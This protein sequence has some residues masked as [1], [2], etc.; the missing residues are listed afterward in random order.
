MRGSMRREIFKV[1][2][3]PEKSP[4]RL[5]SGNL[6]EK[7]HPVRGDYTKLLN[8]NPDRN[9]HFNSDRNLYFDLNRELT[10]DL[11]RSLSF[12]PDRDLGIGKRGIV[13]R[14]YVCSSCGALVNPM[15]TECD[16]CDAVFEKAPKRKAK[17]PKKSA[18]VKRRFCH[19]CGY[20]TTGS[21]AYCSHC[22]MRLPDSPGRVDRTEGEEASG[23]QPYDALKL[24]KKEARKKT[25]T[26]W[27]D[28]GKRLE[29][30]LE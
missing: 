29:D 23:E 14:G 27:K 4:Q 20:P 15:A 30:F 3:A 13:F 28:T 6:F 25:L 1:F 19:Y 18:R 2:M 11:D 22:G 7:T 17:K 8:F 12:D 24:P 5:Y 9:L 21:D 16:E 10:F 26:D